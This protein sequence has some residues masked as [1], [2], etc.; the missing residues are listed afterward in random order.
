MQTTVLQKMELRLAKAEQE[1]HI[2][3]SLGGS[4]DMLD[5]YISELQVQIIDLKLW[6]ELKA[7]P[8]ARVTKMFG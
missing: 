5:M 6:E 1:K 4:T 2:T 3:E 7:R 8:K